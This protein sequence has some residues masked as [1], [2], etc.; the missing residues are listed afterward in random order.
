MTRRSNGFAM[1]ACAASSAVG[2]FVG[3]GG[4]ATMTTRGAMVV[5]VDPGAIEVVFVGRARV[6]V[7]VRRTVGLV[8]DEGT[9]RSMGAS[10]VVI[11]FGAS[12]RSPSA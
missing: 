5:D 12:P 2:S 3:A 6:V 9:T 1:A 7:V 11:R 8:V 4:G 10:E